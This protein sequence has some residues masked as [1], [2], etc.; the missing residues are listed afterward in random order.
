MNICF[1]SI[2]SG[3]LLNLSIVLAGF[4]IYNT[5]IC[6]NSDPDT[7]K[8]NI[9][10]SNDKKLEITYISDNTNI[11]YYKNKLSKI[12]EVS[13][14]NNQVGYIENNNKKVHIDYKLNGIDY[15]ITVL[16]EIDKKCDHV[17]EIYNMIQKAE[18][19]SSDINNKVSNINITDILKKFQ[20]PDYNFYEN[21]LGTSYL[22]NDILYDLVDYKIYNK[23]KIKTILEDIEI[24]ISED[25][26]VRY[27]FML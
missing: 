17:L 1:I 11:E 8:L 18:L 3:V 9:P 26:D 5:Y 19:C 15:S 6:I 16:G 4:I 22:L 2:T 13:E 12:F 7:Q 23:L 10:L 24:D 27:I 14:E 20:G 25:T 21:I